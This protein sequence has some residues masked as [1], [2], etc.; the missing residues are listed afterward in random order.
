MDIHLSKE[1]EVP[2]RQQLAEQIV[3]SITTGKLRTGQ[4][5]PSVRA[6][7]RRLKIHHN[8]VS[9]AYQD[10][11]RRTW[12]TRQ[13]GS[14]HVVGLRED[15]QTTAVDKNLD[16]FINAAIRSAREMGYSLQALRDR[17][18][19]RLLV[20]PADHILV[21]EPD[22]GLREI[23]RKEIQEALVWRVEACSPNDLKNAPELAIGAQVATPDYAMADVEP[24]VP[25]QR[26]AVSITFS[27]ADKCV[28][29]VRSL[30]DPSVISVVSV[31][32][33][34]LKTARGL[35]APALGRRHELREILL[36]SGGQPDLRAAD[37][38]FCDS[39]VVDAVRCPRKIQY[40]LV[41]PAC[42]EYLA[43][44]LLPARTRPKSRSRSAAATR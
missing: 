13:R 40:R 42:L 44:T 18:Y 38:A 10:L 34:L 27:A 32:E 24:V 6:L 9:E 4:Q 36:E 20:Q 21:V 19:R 22:A 17:V 37:I 11:V 1:S 15:G 41:A 14:R 23:M 7:A 26:P 16:D 30:R 43:S 29:M 28:E 5:L 39:L 3:F 2:L 35:L 33:I 8:T 31:S 25:K 12:V